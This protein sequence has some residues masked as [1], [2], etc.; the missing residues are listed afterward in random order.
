M[1]ILKVEGK[2]NETIEKRGKKAKEVEKIKQDRATAEQQKKDQ[3]KK[4]D[5]IMKDKGKY[6]AMY[7]VD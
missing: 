1:S 7:V 3:E 2:V 6:E 4:L 5:T